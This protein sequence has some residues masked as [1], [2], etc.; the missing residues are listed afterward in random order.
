[1]TRKAYS[2]YIVPAA[3]RVAANVAF[4]L[5]NGDD[6][7]TSEAFSA[8]ANV[9]GDYNDPHTHYLGGMPTTAEWEATVGNLAGEMVAGAWPYGE[10]T[11]AAAIAAAAA[12]H[13]QITVTQ[14]GS[15]PSPLQTL[16][17]ALDALGLKRAEVTEA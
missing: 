8:P 15:E 16:Q 13:L 12:V 1:M 6:P 2:V 5:V 17:H 10:V 4:A 3:H 9:S 14:D 11:E 7:L